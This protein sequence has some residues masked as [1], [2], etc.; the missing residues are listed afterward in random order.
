[1]HLDTGTRETT[2]EAKFVHDLT[3]ELLEVHANVSQ[4][5]D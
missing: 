5:I 4:A 1:M 2:S 3:H